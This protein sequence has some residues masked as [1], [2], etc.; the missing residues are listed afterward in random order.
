MPICT[1]T[2]LVSSSRRCLVGLSYKSENMVPVVAAHGIG[3]CVGPL[4]VSVIS[5]LN[6]PSGK[7]FVVSLENPLVAKCAAPFTAPLVLIVNPNACLKSPKF[8]VPGPTC[9]NTTS[10][11]PFSTAADQLRF[12]AFRSGGPPEGKSVDVGPAALVTPKSPVRVMVVRLVLEVAVGKI[13]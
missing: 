9:V 5:R 2:W 11:P 1:T 13:E 3:G 4:V 12:T 8:P 6:V 7:A 10:V